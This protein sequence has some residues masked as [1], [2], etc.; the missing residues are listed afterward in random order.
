MAKGISIGGKYY[1]LEELDNLL[2]PISNKPEKKKVVVPKKVVEKKIE[3]TEP[4]KD[5]TGMLGELHKEKMSKKDDGVIEGD[6]VSD[7]LMDLGA[8]GLGMG[9]AKLLGRSA[10]KSVAGKVATSIPPVSRAIS[11]DLMEGKVTPD[12]VSKMSKTVRDEVLDKVN[13]STGGKMSVEL[14]TVKVPTGKTSFVS[15]NG[16]LAS[17][18]GKSKLS[19]LLKRLNSSNKEGF[20]TISRDTLKKLNLL[21]E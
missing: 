12:R 1:D 4:G 11:R 18:H 8:G 16:E 19:Q 5:A 17:V 14:R 2:A 3:F 6:I 13:P 15:E 7:T 10:G 20:D 21:A 9:I